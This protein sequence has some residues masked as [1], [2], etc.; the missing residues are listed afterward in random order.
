MFL[1]RRDQVNMLYWNPDTAL[2]VYNGHW[3]KLTEYFLSELSDNISPSASSFDFYELV[4]TCL[5][6]KS[7][8]KNYDPSLQVKSNDAY[9]IQS[10]LKPDSLI[11]DSILVLDEKS[12]LAHRI[13]RL[14]VYFNSKT[15]YSP[16]L[17]DA[18]HELKTK[19]PNSTHIKQFE[20]DAENV[21]AYL[22]STAEKFDKAKVIETNYYR[23]EDLLKLFKGQNLLIDIWATWCGPCIAEFKYKHHYKTFVDQGD[24]TV[25]YISIDKQR[26]EKKWRDN[27]KYNQLEGYH[28]RANNVLI[29]DMWEFIGGSSGVIPRYVLIDKNGQIFINDS[30]RPREKKL[31]EEQ[32][33]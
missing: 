10:L 31:P 33:K 17:L 23:F 5:H 2:T 11:L 6:I 12:A 22:N 4:Q 30:A 7:N 14:Y 29:K 26:W 1:K 25:L 16:T 24:L 28:V 32:I 19:Y 18:Y 8:Y 15:F 20:S 3:E 27:M 9:I 21:K 13:K